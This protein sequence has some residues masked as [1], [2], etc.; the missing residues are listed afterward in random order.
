MHLTQ[1]HVACFEC[2]LGV[3]ICWLS[4]EMSIYRMARNCGTRSF[5][6]MLTNLNVDIIYILYIISARH[7][8]L[9]QYMAG[10]R[11]RQQAIDRFL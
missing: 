4:A 6:E 10:F 9:V 8:F 11:E 1:S 5:I 2:Y 7:Y 3:T